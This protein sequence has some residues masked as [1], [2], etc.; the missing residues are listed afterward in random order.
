MVFCDTL[1]IGE[2][3][4]KV[5]GLPYAH[6]AHSRKMRDVLTKGSRFIVIR[7]YDESIWT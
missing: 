5:T 7:I 1:S 2:S 3:A 6:G 4:S